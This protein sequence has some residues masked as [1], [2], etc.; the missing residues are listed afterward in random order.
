MNA[1]TQWQRHAH[2]V[3]MQPWKSPLW[4][5]NLII[6]YKIIYYIELSASDFLNSGCNTP[7]V[8]EPE[9]ARI[10]NCT[11]FNNW[12]SHCNTMRVTCIMGKHA[13]IHAFNCW[14]TLKLP[15]YI[16]YSTANSFIGRGQNPDC[17]TCHCTLTE[18][19]IQIAFN[20][21]QLTQPTSTIPSNGIINLST[22]YAFI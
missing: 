20:G 2:Q 10:P 17:I 11:N 15:E 16:M 19:D 12:I 13:Y 8:L 21:S 14:A 6:G 4:C 7:P 18:K 3:G 9:T 1:A 5:Y 22:M